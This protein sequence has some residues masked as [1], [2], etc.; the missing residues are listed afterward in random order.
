MV[1][2]PCV[3][4]SNIVCV[5][6]PP[7]EMR[8]TVTAMPVLDGPT[9]GVT[10]AVRSVVSPGLS[11]GGFAEPATAKPLQSCVGEAVLRG[12]GVAALKSPALLFES[13]QPP[14][15]RKTALVLLGA[16]VGPLP[17]KQ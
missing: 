8:F 12:V 1:T 11:V 6:L 9:P 13:V 14:L 2:S 3:P 15:A 4:S 17:S 7:M 16:G 10:V 5:A